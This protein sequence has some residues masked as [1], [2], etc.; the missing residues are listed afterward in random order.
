M[1]SRFRTILF[2][3]GYTLVFPNLE[4]LAENLVRQG[5]PITVQDFHAAERG[6]KEKLDAWLLPRLASAERVTRPDL[7]YWQEYLRILAK[8]SNLPWIARVRFVSRVVK[9]FRNIQFWSRVDPSTE[10]FL[11]SLRDRGYRLGVVSNATGKMR[12]QLVRLDLAK[13]FDF[14]FDSA[15]V[16]IEKPSPAIFTMAVHA[17][18]GR[19][20]EAVFVGDSYS[21]DVAGAAYAGIS[22]V[23]MDASGAY[24]HRSSGISCPWITSLVGLN[25]ILEHPDVAGVDALVAD[26][27]ERHARVLA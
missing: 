5:Y 9:A 13:H 1:N 15:V 19:A 2:D 12:E 26:P 25:Q 4:D 16:G 10:P 6:G 7:V 18:R 14:I 11:E 23:L 8:R 24:A 20:S 3:A 17:A 21:I 22:G 27:E